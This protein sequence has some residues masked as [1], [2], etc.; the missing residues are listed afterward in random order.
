[1][2]IVPLLAILVGVTGAAWSWKLLL[3]YISANSVL[4]C[5]LGSQCASVFASASSYFYGTPIHLL[6]VAWF[7]LMTILAAATAYEIKHAPKVGLVVGA[8]CVPAIVYLDYIQLAVIHAICSDCELA[9]AL[10]LILFILF[11]VIYRSDRR[12]SKQES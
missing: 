4:Y 11:V 1:M 9:H 5:V 6:A 2:R 8:L 7:T 12:N 3:W 10:G